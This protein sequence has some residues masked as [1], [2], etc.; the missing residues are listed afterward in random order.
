MKRKNILL[1][2][3]LAAGLFLPGSGRCDWESL[4]TSQAP[5]AVV[6]AST[7]AYQVAYTIGED[8]ASPYNM[9][10]SSY[11]ALSGYLSFIPS[12]I[13]NQGFYGF[14]SG[15]GVI[16]EGNL[17]GQP[18][19][20]SVKLLFSTDLS[21]TLS[22]PSVNVTQVLDN[23]A[24]EISSNWFVTT[25]Y[26]GQKLV[27]VPSAAWPKGSLFA[28]YYSSAIVD[29]NGSPVSGATTVYFSVMMDY[30]K[31]NTATAISDHKV[32]VVIPSNAY[33]EDFF[34]TLST[35]AARPEIVT[36]NAKLAAQPGS[37]EFLNLVHVNPY[38]A[39]GNPVQPN[40]ACVVTLPYSLGSDGFVAGT[41]GRVKTSNLAI[42]LMD[43]TRHLWVK[44]TG[45]SLDA[46]GKNLSMP[47]SH[48]SSYGLLG[49]PDTDLTPVFAYPVPFRPNAGN[50]ARYGT[51]AQG[52]TFTNLPSSGKISIYTVSGLLVRDL[53]V[54]GAT[55]PWDVKNSDGEVVASGVYL[56][57]VTT[58]GNR[59]TG[60]LVVIK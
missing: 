45:A 20:Q 10:Y 23:Y 19:D 53:P 43:E 32:R 5:V 47:V 48:F 56:W 21:P 39:A 15:T 17:W 35:N 22:T 31:A 28:V 41:E 34:L 30:T 11:S 58:G 26:S 14:D 55:Q 16:L 8:C 51:W 4:R 33:S 6:Y 44:Q 38:D 57:E 29:I 42:W 2:I 50:P 12:S 13:E 1:S 59:K 60:K 54:M 36:A 18:P 24:N 9:V 40:A 3:A 46:S 49:L 37:P 25:S 52:I 27:I 7:G